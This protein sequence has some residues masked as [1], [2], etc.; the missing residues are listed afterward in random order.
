LNSQPSVSN[1]IGISWNSRNGFEYR[2]N[3]KLEDDL[4]DAYLASMNQPKKKESAISKLWKS[5]R[6]KNSEMCK[7]DAVA[8]TVNARLSNAYLVEARMEAISKL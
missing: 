8:E 7:K 4:A 6:P 5:S 3:E 2:E 1:K